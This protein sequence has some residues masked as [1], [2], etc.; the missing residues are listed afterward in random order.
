VIKLL[1]GTLAFLGCLFL[2][3]R[4][5]RGLVQQ[6]NTLN[7]AAE[8]L[9]E[10]SRRLEWNNPPLGELLDWMAQREGPLRPVYEACQAELQRPDRRPFS[11]IWRAAVENFSRLPPQGR[12]VL[13]QAGLLLGQYQ[14]QR[15]EEGL[16]ALAQR[17]RTLAEET[18]EKRKGMGRVYWVTGG[19]A[20][21]LLV[22]LLV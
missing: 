18:E 21:L 6:R 11:Q 13:T 12:E 4:Q 10:L 15:Q 16:N 7:R 22:L 14:H 20:G 19:A 17:L 8:D 9:E 1:G 3:G 5:E 2:G